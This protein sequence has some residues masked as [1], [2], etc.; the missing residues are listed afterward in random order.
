MRLRQVVDISGDA[1]DVG[2]DVLTRDHG[3]REDVALGVGSVTM[4][5]EPACLCSDKPHRAGP[6][7]ISLA[8]IT[9]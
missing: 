4:M 9:A 5:N 2:A 1:V 3:S 8:I 6:V 7:F